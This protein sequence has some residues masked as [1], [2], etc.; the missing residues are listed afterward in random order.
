MEL[1]LQL[2]GLRGTFDAL[3]RHSCCSRHV[4]GINVDPEWSRKHQSRSKIQRLLGPGEVWSRIRTTQG[5][6]S[7]GEVSGSVHG[8]LSYWFVNAF[9]H[10][11]LLRVSTQ[12]LTLGSQSQAE[13]IDL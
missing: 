13:P 2:T 4:L 6:L 10:R 7:L 8:S 11:L 5:D 3:A 9:I 1:A 12:I